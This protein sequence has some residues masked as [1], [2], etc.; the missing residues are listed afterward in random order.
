MQKENRHGAKCLNF[1][2]YL[3]LNGGYTNVVMFSV[4]H[5]F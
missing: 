1:K 3:N 2:T 4:T 5:S